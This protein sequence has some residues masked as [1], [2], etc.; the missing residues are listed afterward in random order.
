MAAPSKKDALIVS[1]DP[2]M[3]QALRSELEA[4]GWKTILTNSVGPVPKLLRRGAVDLLLVDEA[5]LSR[6]VSDP[7]RTLL[8]GAG[9]V[10]LLVFLTPERRQDRTLLQGLEPRAILDLPMDAEQVRQA[11]QLVSE[12]SLSTIG[13]DLLGNSTAINRIRETIRQVGPVPVSVLVTGESG[14]GK[15]MVIQAL[16][17]HSARADARLV[18]VNC[19]AI[20]ETLLESELFGH[21][22]GAFTDA[23]TRRQGIFEAADGGTVFLDEIGEMTLT[24]QV[25]L[26]RVLDTREITRLGSTQSIKVDVRVLAA[27]NQD[28]HQA[29]DQGR[30]R[31]DLYHRLRVV[32]LRVPPLRS[33]PEDIPMLVDHFIQLY[34]KEHGV[35]PVE[36]DAGAMDILFNYRWPGNIRELRNLIERL[37]V[38]SVNRRIGPADINQ[39]LEGMD[40]SQVARSATSNLPVH[41]GRT[42]EESQRDL[43]YWAVLEVARDIKELKAYL[44]E[45]TANLPSLP[46]YTQGASPV[47]DRVEEVEYTEADAGPPPGDEIKSLREVERETIARAL[48][49]TGGHRKRAAVLLDMPERTLYRKIQQYQAVSAVKSKRRKQNQRSVSYQPS[50]FSLKQKA[51]TRFQIHYLPNFPAFGGNSGQLSAVSG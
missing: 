11:L 17:R 5:N 23:R 26:L 48:R 28:L 47:A 29:V 32:E 10:S 6:A 50:A 27:T 21:E 37:M 18:T 15:N 38:L 34:R 35:P 9:G 46:A 30:F 51:K 20:P 41:V 8:A 3:G 1:A 39:H 19:G 12:Q 31:S 42:P 14:S 24:A 2:D 43:L 45:N 13:T 22:K 7:D 16:H 33:H 25:R 36:L 4:Q 44:M 40:P 49:A